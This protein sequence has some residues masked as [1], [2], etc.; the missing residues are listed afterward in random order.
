MPCWHCA[1]VRAT[2]TAYVD[3]HAAV[4]MV[5]AERKLCA[6]S[7][8]LPTIV[9]M[10]TCNRT[11]RCCSPCYEGLNV[12]VVASVHFCFGSCLLEH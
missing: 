2:A 4:S 12:N 8:S 7:E 9:T 3:A 6:L 1:A 10:C 11:K 5:A